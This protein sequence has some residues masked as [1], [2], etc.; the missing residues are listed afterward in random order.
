MAKRTGLVI[1]VILVIL[2]IVYVAARKLQSFRRPSAVSGCP[3]W[4]LQQVNTADETVHPEKI[5]VEPLQGR[6]NVYG[7]FRLPEGYTPSPFFVVKV[8]GSNPYCGT[9]I[10]STK[11][12]RHSAQKDDQTFIGRFRTRTTLWLITKGQ[13]DQLNHR[14]NWSLA[15][16][17]YPEQTGE[18]PP[19]EKSNRQ[20]RLPD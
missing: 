15:I 7:V 12:R 16:V 3:D 2:P 9:I 10:P 1:L 13:A 19:S 8:E 6:H 18:A 5:V 14:E 11:D 17:K 4:V 20:S